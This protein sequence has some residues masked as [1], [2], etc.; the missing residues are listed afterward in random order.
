MFVEVFTVRSGYGGVGG[1][2]FSLSEWGYVG[3]MI[4]YDM[5]CDAIND[6]TLLF[7]L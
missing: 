6:T 5:L 1:F 4:C 7:T 2:F 3:G